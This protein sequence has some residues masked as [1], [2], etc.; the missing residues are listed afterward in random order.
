MSTAKEQL[1]K[2]QNKKK[3]S[4][5][6]RKLN[7][8]QEMDSAFEKNWKGLWQAYN[9]YESPLI[10]LRVYLRDG[11]DYLGILKREVGVKD[12]IL[13]SGADDLLECLDNLS[14][15]VQSEKWKKDKPHGS[16]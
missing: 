7:R 14:N 16:S 12:E 5:L 1:I 3:P 2:K 13:F 8:L 10:E 4:R 15:A 9:D 11:G 6:E